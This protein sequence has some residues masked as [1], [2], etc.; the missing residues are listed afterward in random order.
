MSDTAF[1]TAVGCNE[2]ACCNARQ[3][4]MVLAGPPYDVELVGLGCAG[5]ESRLCCAL[6]A[7]GEEVI[8]IGRLTYQT[9][10]LLL[11]SPKLCLRPN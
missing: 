7:R 11:E 1:S 9:G 2:G 3:A 5:D 6:S 8:A 4:K 10:R